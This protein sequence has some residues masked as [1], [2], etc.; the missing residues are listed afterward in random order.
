[1]HISADVSK[2]A[3]SRHDVLW[4][5]YRIRDL[6][7]ARGQV[8]EFRLPVEA[9]SN[10]FSLEVIA[11][12][13]TKECRMHGRQFFHNVGAISVGAVVVSG[14]KQLYQTQP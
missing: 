5:L 12:G 13:K 9:V 7:T 6:G 10:V 2:R 1:M 8:H 14:W 3:F 11:A 4:C